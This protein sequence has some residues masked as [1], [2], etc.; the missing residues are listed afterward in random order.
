MGTYQSKFFSHENWEY[1]LT[2]LIRNKSRQ[3]TEEFVLSEIER[4][5]SGIDGSVISR[6]VESAD[7]LYV[8]VAH[9]EYSI[10]L[11]AELSRSEGFSGYGLTK[12]QVYAV[13]SPQDIPAGVKPYGNDFTERDRLLIIPLI[14]RYGILSEPPKIP[15]V[16]VLHRKDKDFTPE[17]I[18]KAKELS[19]HFGYLM[20]IYYSTNL[21]LSMRHIEELGRKMITEASLYRHSMGNFLGKYLMEAIKHIEGAEAGSLL[22]EV[23]GGFKFIAV[24]GYPSSLLKLPPIS[25]K[26]HLNWYYYGE[27]KLRKGI[28]RIITRRVIKELL[29]EDIVLKSSEKTNEIQSTLGIPIV[30]GEKV[31][32]F[33][34]L[35]SFS[36]PV[37]FD[38]TDIELAKVMGTYFA[39]A[40]E[41]LSG[42][43]KLRKRDIVIKR[44]NKLAQQMTQE[45]NITEHTDVKDAFL[46][47]VAK[48]L[49]I[50]KPTTILL[51]REK[52]PEHPVFIGKEDN[53]LYHKVLRLKHRAK[54]YGYTA[55]TFKKQNLLVVYKEIYVSGI[56]IQ[57]YTTLLR[58]DIWSR[59]DLDY[60]FSILNSATIYIK[61]LL[62]LRAIRK[63]QE[64]TLKMLGKALEVRDI[65]TQGHTERTAKLSLR[66]AKA[67]GLKDIKGI[68]W[69]AYIHDIGKIA[70]PDSILLKPGKLSY[71]EF[72]IIKEHVSIGYNLIKH[73]EGLPE[74][75]KNIV[76]YHHEKWD[77]TGYLKGLRSEEIPIEARIFAVIDVF[78][79]LVS[80]RPYKEPW[81]MAKALE[82]IERLSGTH[83]DPR[84][85]S[86]FLH[87]MK[88]I[89]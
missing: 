32:L 71:D 79:A 69:G 68:L 57:L 23:P 80:K 64:E 3:Q 6:N 16:V 11:H 48:G 36:S 67:L 78:D 14:P 30:G 83:F 58:E 59:A 89:V 77:G 2:R 72:Q 51:L 86:T 41:I 81:P 74:T 85:V 55:S 29:G 26:N 75:T 56:K 46:S 82:E 31:V 17:E 12:R 15:A 88:N 66:L 60:I 42:K 1:I 7:I 43:N 84:V 53:E 35:D 54:S 87:M 39:A 37:A 76:L 44:M 22:I 34:N 20:D 27:M 18:A 45:E 24:S 19:C 10:Y 21:M 9:G 25:R 5:F 49:D 70:I 4:H 28:P 61:N 73:I 65:E 62:Y 38:D 52:Y 50:L 13:N 8:T 63:T 40:Y 33:V 47:V